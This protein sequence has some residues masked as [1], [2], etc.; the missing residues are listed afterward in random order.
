MHHLWAQPLSP[1]RKEEI[2][3]RVANVIKKHRLEVP[4]ILF[5]E[6]HKP[7]ANVAAHLGLGIS[8]FL[9]PFFGFQSV[10]EYTQF[11]A[12]RENIEELIRR[13]EEKEVSP[14]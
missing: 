2:I 6:M 5:L 4:A 10:D 1:E 12:D 13:L 9:M 14:T 7:L 11:I 3:N 8:P